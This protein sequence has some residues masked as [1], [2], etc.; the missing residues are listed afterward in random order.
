MVGAKR[1]LIVG[2]G[3]RE[4][5][6]AWC[7]AQSP[8]VSE[9]LV[10]PG[11]AG[12]AHEQRCRNV[13][14]GA[15]DL[16]A[17]IDLAVSEAVDLVVV[18]PEDPLVAGL[19]DGLEEA[20]VPAFGPTAAAAQL[21]GS[22]AHCK[23]FLVRNGIPTAAAAR[24]DNIDAALVYLGTLDSPPVV[25]AS[26]LAAGKGV[27]VADTFDEASA[28]VEEMLVGGRFGTAG[29]EILLEERLVGPEVSILAFCDG[30]TF[31]VM[32]TAQDH[33]RLLEG[34]T[35]PN[36]GGMGAFH[37]SPTADS[38]VV[39]RISAEVLVPTLAALAAEGRPYRGVLYAGMMLTASGPKVI[40]FNCRFGDPETQVVLPL[41]QSDLFDVM[42]ACSSGQLSGQ[43][44]HWDA[45][46]AT[47]IVMASKGYPTSK[48]DPTPIRGIDDAEASGCKVFHAG[49]AEVAGS[50]VTAGG[51][52]LAVTAV[53]QDRDVA[54]DLAYEG[55]R[56]I[57]FEGAQV[58]ADIGRALAPAR[59]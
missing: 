42:T 22:K 33:K 50:V 39:S 13:S 40:E 46:A 27:I 52:V 54:T 21:E 20:G 5:A 53:A 23:E 49:T 15:T 16:E 51:R 7:M 25:K 26:G 18:G 56:S 3:G 6:I 38:A 17:Q 8:Q 58:R 37:P 14:I 12:T 29:Q 2:G 55:V 28:A 24:F 44:I 4:H 59:L 47:T 36:T 32:P 35:G 57:H 31:E 10:A 41:L 30:T 1:V 11:N 9:V 19:V 43:N 34:D 45:N 48:S